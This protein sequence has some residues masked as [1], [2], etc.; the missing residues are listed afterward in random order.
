MVSKIPELVEGFGIAQNDSALIFCGD[1]RIAVQFPINLQLGIVPGQRPLEFG[2]IVV[3]RLIQH[4]RGFR[5]DAESVR[6]ASRNPHHSLV[7]AGK[8]RGFPLAECWRTSAQIHGYIENLSIRNAHQ[9]PLRML[10]LVVQSAQN[11]SG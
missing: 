11:I 9:F 4:V 7:F 2:R 6:K 5:N 1:D 3:G 8:P 10:N